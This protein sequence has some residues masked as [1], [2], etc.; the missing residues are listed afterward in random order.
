MRVNKN[1]LMEWLWLQIIKNLVGYLCIGILVCTI[2]LFIV[3]QD[4]DMK[5]VTV[6]DVLLIVSGIGLV[7]CNYYADIRPVWIGIV[8]VFLNFII[9]F[10]CLL[11]SK[12]LHAPNLNIMGIVYGGI[13][14]LIIRIFQRRIVSTLANLFQHK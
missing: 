7:W 13:S 9:F 11:L 10:L 14:T 1:I 3:F 12:W 4:K 5:L 8:L 2:A 6:L